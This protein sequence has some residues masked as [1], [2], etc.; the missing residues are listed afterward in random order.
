MARL[1][2]IIRCAVGGGVLLLAAGWYLLPF[3]VERPTLQ[4]EPDGRVY[5]RHGEYLGVVA[6]E[7]GY[8]HIPLQQLPPNL[9]R[10]ILAAEDRHF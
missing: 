6:G 3:C 1:R 8:R 5:D 2:N 9:V 4:A 7:D 10:C